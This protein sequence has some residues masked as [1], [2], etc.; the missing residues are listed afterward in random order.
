MIM[1]IL[2]WLVATIILGLI[3]AVP[4]YVCANILLWLFHVS[5]RWKLWEAFLA[6][7]CVI[8]IRNFLMKDDEK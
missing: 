8:T 4:V 2:L 6:C 7:V 3:Y 5:F 1:M